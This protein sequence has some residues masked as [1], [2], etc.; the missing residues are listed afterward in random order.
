M[1]MLLKDHRAIPSFEADVVVDEGFYDC[2][3]ISVS[4]N[5]FSVS[6]SLQLSI[7]IS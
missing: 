5:H 6:T 4:V 3:L 1:W 7:M 2:C